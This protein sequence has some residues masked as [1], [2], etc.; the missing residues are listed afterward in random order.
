MPQISKSDCIQLKSNPGFYLE[1]NAAHAWDRA[2]AAFG[3]VVLISGAW[4]SY[5]TQVQLFDSELFPNTGRYV[6][7]NHAGKRGFTTDVRGKMAD[8]SLYRGSWW[9]RKAG[10]AA[11]AVPGTSNHGAG[12]SVDAL[13][14]RDDDDPPYAVAVIF[15]GWEDEDRTRFLRIAKEH[16][17]DDDEGQSV[18]EFWHLTYYASRDQHRGE[19]VPTLPEKEKDFMAMM[20]E[21]EKKVLLDAAKS[22]LQLIPDGGARDTQAGSLRKNL[23]VTRRVD[24]NAKLLLTEVRGLR[25]TVDTLVKNAGLDPERIYTLLDENLKAATA[26]LKITFSTE[27][28]DEEGENQ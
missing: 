27:D 4:R 12:L 19:A 7:G 3:K 24:G 28:E 16:G 14:G 9:T 11:A 20:S 21:A 8:G 6:R 23:I 13:T 15:A 26:D 2:N 17:W 22:S 5:E 1:K 10:T 25:T 18:K